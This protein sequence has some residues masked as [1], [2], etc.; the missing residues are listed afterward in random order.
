MPAAAAAERTSRFRAATISIEQEEW[1]TLHTFV[2][3]QAIKRLHYDVGTAAC[4]M[5][6]W[7]FFAQPQTGCNCETLMSMLV[8][9]KGYTREDPY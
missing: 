4:H 1:C 3:I 8:I 6:Q 9:I 5:H 2:A 7:A